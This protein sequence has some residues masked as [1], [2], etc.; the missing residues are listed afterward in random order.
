MAGHS[1]WKNIQKRKNAQDSKR[2][3]I[4]MKLAKEIYVAAKTSGT[5]PESNA[6][7]RLV[8]DKAK[9]SNMPNDNIERAIKKADGSKDNNSYEEITYEG[10]GP[11]GVAVMVKCL[12][13][14]KNRTATNVRTAFNKNGGSLGES[15]CVAYMFE[16]KGYLAIERKGLNVDEDELMLEVIEAGA[17][18]LET[19][20][21]SFEIYT[22]AEQFEQVKHTLEKNEYSLDSAE[23]TMIPQTYTEVDETDSEKVEKLIDVLEDDDD[24]QEVYHNM[25]N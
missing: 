3:K 5:D 15:G 7:L 18:E 2:G 22:E 12:T 8:I 14:N 23:I 10:Y 25:E 19:S 16:R 17:E 24:V 20:D 11:S 13:D 6:S 21:E 1:K 4:F 9:Q